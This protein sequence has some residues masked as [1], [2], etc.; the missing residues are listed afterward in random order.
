MIGKSMTEIFPN[1]LAEKYRDSIRLAAETGLD[2]QRLDGLIRGDGSMGSFIVYRFPI[3]ESHP[4][5]IGGI[6]IDVTEQR[7]VEKELAISEEKYRRIVDTMHEGIWV[8]DTSSKIKLVNEQLADMLGYDVDELVGRPSGEFLVDDR[9]ALVL[10]GKNPKD[11]NRPH[12]ATLIR[13]DST[14]VQILVSATPIYTD[15]GQYEGALAIFM[16]VTE[17]MRTHEQL[18]RLTAKLLSLQDEERRRIARELHD[19]TAQNLA[20]IGINLS[21]LKQLSTSNGRLG[22]ILDQTRELT[23]T[24]LQEIRTMSYLLHPP[25]LEEAGL[26]SALHWFIDGYT[27]RTGIA[28]KLNVSD[29][30]GRLASEIET[31][32]YRIVQEGLNNVYRHSGSPVAGISLERKGADVILMIRDEGRGMPNTPRVDSGVGIRGMKERLRLLGGKLDI[33][34]GK[35]GTT[36]KSEI[37]LGGTK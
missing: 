16:D 31:A 32:I 37:P 19:G 23:D 22:K 26:V 18:E 12:A 1:D 3:T 2:V 17:R 10:K 15:G 14:S 6:A 25:M 9:S 8:L 36:F 4:R 20:A 35:G 30:V 27:D 13:K 28:V 21:T 11:D 34:S 7:R 33:V 5:L 24:A 29:G